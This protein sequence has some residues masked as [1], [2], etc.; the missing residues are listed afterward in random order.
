MRVFVPLQRCNKTSHVQLVIQDFTGN[1]TNSYIASY[2]V[3]VYTIAN[4]ST[5]PFT[6][7]SQ[8]NNT[9]PSS[10]ANDTEPSSQANHTAPS[11][12]AN[13]TEPPFQSN[14]TE[15]T[16]QPN[17]TKPPSQ[18]NHIEPPSLINHTEAPDLD[19]AKIGDRPSLPVTSA[20]TNVGLSKT[21]IFVIPSS[22]LAVTNTTANANGVESSSGLII[23]LG[24]G[25]G[26]ALLLAAIFASV[27]FIQRHQHLKHPGNGTYYNGDPNP[28]G[29]IGLESTSV[30]AT[31]TTSLQGHMP[32]GYL[33][34]HTGS[35]TTAVLRIGLGSA[36]RSDEAETAF[37]DSVIEST[38]QQRN[39]TIGRNNDANNRSRAT[40]DSLL[41]SVNPSFGA[42]ERPEVPQADLGTGSGTDVLTR[43]RLPSYIN[44]NDGTGIYSHANTPDMSEGNLYTTLK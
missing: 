9:E 3:S 19:G 2:I 5:A 4:H 42:V 10:Q 18:V 23:G 41:L 34:L 15:P 1:L 22:T 24:V 43:G 27:I 38:P 11:S 20:T 32:S 39:V 28:N 29:A 17:H 14:H 26:S 36:S 30:D 35:D 33:N 8:V 25:L 13:H 37:Y 12:Q 40:S 7:T 31:N 44:L 21:S 6:P 16:T